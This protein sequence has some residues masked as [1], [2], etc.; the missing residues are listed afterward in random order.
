MSTPSIRGRGADRPCV[1]GAHRPCHVRRR[2]GRGCH[3]RLG[4]TGRGARQCQVLTRRNIAR[5]SPPVVS[6]AGSSGQRPHVAGRSGRP[7]G[8]RPDARPIRCCVSEAP[9]ASCRIGAGTVGAPDTASV[10]PRLPLEMGG[11]VLRPPRAGWHRH[12]RC[13]LRRP[14]CLRAC[15][16][17]RPALGR[18]LRSCRCRSTPSSRRCSGR[19]AARRAVRR[20]P[21]RA[22]PSLFPEGR[23]AG[24]SRGVSAFPAQRRR[25]G[26]P[27]ASSAVAVGASAVR[28]Q[29]HAAGFSDPVRSA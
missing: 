19:S 3:A 21:I 23:R 6:L 16:I 20:S 14:R 9:S 24:W 17:R 8:P 28:R 29:R 13:R 10:A 18:R 15:R 25:R 5:A 7:T 12:R 1:S 4:A 26:P 11:S 27:E 22:R 2:L